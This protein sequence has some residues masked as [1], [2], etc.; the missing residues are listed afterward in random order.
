MIAHCLCGKV[1]LETLGEPI[2]CAACHCS[3]CFAGSRQIEQLPN[4]SPVLD[5]FGG[6]QHVLYRKDRV[7]YRKG[8]EFF[9]SLKVEAD[10]PGRVYASCCNSYLFMDLPNPMHWVPIFRNRFQGELPPLEMRMNVKAKAEGSDVPKDAP[11]YPSFP[12]QFIV[13]LLRSKFA[14]IFFR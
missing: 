9:K 2:L 12:L 10:S 5:S 8:T 3:D 13:K 14:M 6:T 11:V 4:A 1:E 7:K